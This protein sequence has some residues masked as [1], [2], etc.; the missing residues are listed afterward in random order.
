MQHTSVVC[1]AFSGFV[2][3]IVLPVVAILAKL[4]V[5]QTIAPHIYVRAIQDR[6]AAM[7][8]SLVGRQY[9]SNL[10][11]VDQCKIDPMLLVR[12]LF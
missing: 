1:D 8:Q 2:V 9:L 6:L 12:Y 11:S 7:L 4:F 5:A 10:L 3:G